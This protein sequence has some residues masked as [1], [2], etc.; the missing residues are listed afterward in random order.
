MEPRQIRTAG[1]VLLGAAAPA[2]AGMWVPALRW[3]CLA[4]LAGVALIAH[5]LA[6]RAAYAGVVL[7]I[8]RRGILDLRLLPTHILWQDIE[9]V[10][11]VDLD[12]ARVVDIALR[13]PKPTLAE[14]RWRV[15]IGAWCQAGYGVPAVTLSM[16]LLD[17]SVR[18]LLAAIA[19]HRPDLLAR[20]QTLRV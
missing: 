11:P 10:C 8:D 15:R 18:D 12:R 7:L 9:A 16:L 6:R 14:A 1:F 13:W 2:V 20:G 4:W 17:G 3:F 19:R 5:G